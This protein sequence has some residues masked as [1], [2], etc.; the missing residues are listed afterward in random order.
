[1]TQAQ[2]A[3]QD[4]GKAKTPPDPPKLDF[5]GAMKRG[6]QAEKE[7]KF[8]DALKAYQDALKARPKD[9]QAQRG[10]Q[11]AQAILNAE[12]AIN[13]AM[14]KDAQREVDNAL[15]LQPQHAHALKLQQRVKNKK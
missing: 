7:L 9:P 13:N 15:R 12:Q 8:S 6:A 3:L 14:W 5:D 4:A 1:L 11:F 10:A 2:Q